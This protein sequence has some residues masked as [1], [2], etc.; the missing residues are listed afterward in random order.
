MKRSNILLLIIASVLKLV[1][2]PFL[3]T[4]GAVASIRRREFGDY[5]YALSLTKDKYGNVLGSYAFNYFLLKR[6][7]VK[8][9]L[10]GNPAISISAS[11]GVNE[12]YGALSKT[13]IFVSRVLSVCFA[14]NHCVN[15]A[16]KEKLI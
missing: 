13:G 6:G 2:A 5:D 9:F 8:V 11:I 12:Y 10:F 15:A 16:K 7:A 1:L 14:P 3:Y 4:F